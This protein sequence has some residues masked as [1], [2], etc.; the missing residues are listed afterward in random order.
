MK[1]IFVPFL[2]GFTVLF[3]SSLPGYGKDEKPGN[4]VIKK[5]ELGYPVPAIPFYHFLAEVE[6]PHASIIEVETAVNGKWLRFTDLHKEHEITD[7]DRPA[8]SHRPPSG[9]GLSLDGTYYKNPHIVGWVRWEPGK[10]YTITIKIRMKKA[11]HKSADDVFLTVTKKVKAPTGAG[12]FDLAWKSYKSVVLTETAGIDRKNESV[13]VL[14]PF[15]PD[16]AGQLTRDIRVVAV[17][18]STYALTEVPSQVYDIMKYMK[19]DSLDPDA[20]GK[21]TRDIPYWMPTVTARVSFL[22]D[23]PARKSKVYLVFYNNEHAMAKMYKTTPDVIFCFGFHTQFGGGKTTGFALIYDTL[24]SAKKFEPKY[25]L[26]RVCFQ[27]LP[28]SQN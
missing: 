9:Y 21:P 8:L 22:A 23:V 25:R 16:E 24:D 11:V 18:P 26:A 5:L 10:E 3:V 13:E 1:K 19:K 15:Y 12:V 2:F 6:L 4:L 27:L 20:H 7:M 14:L 17:D 28:A